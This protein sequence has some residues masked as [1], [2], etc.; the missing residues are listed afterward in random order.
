MIR[1]LL[2]RRRGLLGT[3]ATWGVTVA[4]IGLPYT[5]AGQPHLEVRDSIHLEQTVGALLGLPTAVSPDGSGYLVVDAQQPHVFRFDENGRFVQRYGREGEGPGEFK[6]AAAAIPYGSDQILVFSWSP[7][8]AQAFHRNSAE[9]IERFDLSLPVENVLVRGDRVWISGPRYASRTGLRVL[10]LGG[11]DEAHLA[12]LPDAFREAGPLGGIFP[13]VPFAVWGDT[14]MV[15][16]EPSNSLLLL[17]DD[18]SVLDT[19]DVPIERRR[20][21]PDDATS[22]LLEAMRSGRY[23][24]VFGVLST[25]RA[26]HR[27]Q[28]GSTTLVHYD[29]RPEGPPVTSEVYV[30]VLSPDRQRAC[31]DARVPL[32]PDSSPA[33]GFRGDELLVLE[34]VIEGLEAVPVLRSLRVDVSAC[35]WISTNS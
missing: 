9:F 12:P 5:A 32:G 4:A 30:S 2:R 13:S 18:G 20:G 31:V 21:V 16:F 33:I 7:P 23:A 14:V 25:L 17:V 24:N 26:V 27:N 15:G 28:D 34:Q 19:I 1:G 35:S 6:K 29:H 22:R 3:A 10:T 11:D 8:A